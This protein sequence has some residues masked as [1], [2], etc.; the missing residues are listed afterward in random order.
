MTRP[1]NLHFAIKRDR[2]G[3]LSSRQGRY[4][5]TNGLIAMRMVTE[6]AQSAMPTRLASVNIGHPVVQIFWLEPERTKGIKC[7][8]NGEEVY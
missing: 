2:C 5:L 4:A 7:M 8:I 6:L 3:I 1:V